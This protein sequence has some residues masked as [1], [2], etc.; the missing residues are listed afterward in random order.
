MS[1]PPLKPL[2]PKITLGYVGGHAPWIS[3]VQTAWEDQYGPPVYLVRISRPGDYSDLL[4]MFNDR[5][6]VS[7]TSDPPSLVSFS[8]EVDTRML[9]S[10]GF[11]VSWVRAVTGYGSAADEQAR[12]CVSVPVPEVQTV[13]K[14]LATERRLRFPV[15]LTALARRAGG[16][17][18]LSDGE[19]LACGLAIWY[20]YSRDE[21]LR[22]ERPRRVIPIQQ[23]DE[24]WESEMLG[25]E[26]PFADAL[27]EVLANRGR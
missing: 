25:S 11:D 21:E 16:E 24:S 2:K 26:D 4:E 15:T 7:D 3:V 9:E 5:R 17:L 14:R 23:D 12:S 27:A 10:I 13:L 8:D 19:L 22:A 18:D 20:S 6:I 1:A